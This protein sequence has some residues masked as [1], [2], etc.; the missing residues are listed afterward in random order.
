[1]NLSILKPLQADW[2]IKLYNKMTSLSGKNVI[3]KGWEKAGIK[4]GIEM[5]TAGLPSLDPFGEVDPLVVRGRNE[6]FDYDLLAALSINNDRLEEGCTTVQNEE[7]GDDSEW[8]DPNE[9]GSAFDIF[10]DDD[11]WMKYMLI[12]YFFFFFVSIAK[13]STNK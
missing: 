5:G 2:I 6:I 8:E 4:D 7:D 12:I 9:D 13:F 3:L 10:E 1:M 11:E